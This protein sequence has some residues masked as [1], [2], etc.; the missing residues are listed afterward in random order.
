[1]PDQT[2]IQEYARKE[3]RVLR[4][5]LL[6]L[7]RRN[8]LLNFR[9]RKAAK[10]QL[11]IVD[12]VLE[13]TFE[14]LVSGKE[15]QIDPLPDPED[16]TLDPD[17][18][19]T[20]EFNLALE[21]LKE[22]DEFKAKAETLEMKLKTESDINAYERARDKLIREIK[23][24]VR[25]RLGMPP[26]G[27]SLVNSAVDWAKINGIN[28][29]YELLA[30]KDS[31]GKRHE[32]KKLQTLH[33]HKSLDGKLNALSTKA[34]LIM[35][36]KGVNTLY[37]AFSFL[38]WYESKNSNV[39]LLSPLILLPLAIEKDFKRGEQVY[40]IQ[41]SGDPV[42]NETLRV[43]LQLD[44]IELPQIDE[45]NDFNLEDYL[46]S[47]KDVIAAHKRWKIHRYLTLGLFSFHKIAMYED[48]N[49][50]NG[51]E[52]NKPHENALVSSLLAGRKRDETELS[53]HPP[54]YNPDDYES[55]DELPKLI[56]DSDSSQFSAVV[57][58]LG[59]KNLIIQGPPGTGKSQTI[60]NIIGAAMMRDKSV[61]FVSEKLSALQVVKKRLDEFGIGNYCLEIHS[62]KSNRADF[63]NELSTRLTL[64]PPSA[65]GLPELNISELK[66][67][68]KRL[69]RYLDMLSLEIGHSK[70]TIEEALWLSQKGD[71]NKLPLDVRRFRFKNAS[72]I[73]RGD[74]TLLK[75]QLTSL[76]RIRKDV[77]I[78]VSM[79]PWIII[80]REDASS[81][82]VADIKQ[83]L[84]MLQEN[85]SATINNVEAL[86]ESFSEVCPADLQ[87][88]KQ[89]LDTLSNLPS[90][91]NPPE[92]LYPFLALT[93][94]T[95]HE[96]ALKLQEL[97]K[98]LSDID[99]QVKAFDKIQGI[100]H[101][102][103][104]LRL[105]GDLLD[106]LNKF[107]CKTVEELQASIDLARR[108][109]V[110][111]EQATRIIS[112]CKEL[113]PQ[114]LLEMSFSAVRE[115]L[116]VI[117][118]IRNYPEAIPEV[119]YSDKL[120]SAE[121]VSHIKHLK[122]K[123]YRLKISQKSLIE[124]FGMRQD[125]VFNRDVLTDTI[126][127]LKNKGLF[128]FFRGKYRR[129]QKYLA[130]IYSTKKDDVAAIDELTQISKILD[131][132]KTIEDDSIFSDFAVVDD[133]EKALEELSAMASWFEQKI[134]IQEVNK[135]GYESLFNGNN[136]GKIDL[137]K[138]Q[139]N[140]SQL[141]LISNL[142]SAAEK[143]GTTSVS[144]Y[145]KQLGSKVT[146]FE[147]FLSTYP[148]PSDFSEQPIN[149]L[150]FLQGAAESYKRIHAE[151]EQST[152]ELDS[153]MSAA[154]GVTAVKLMFNLPRVRPIKESQ[155]IKLSGQMMTLEEYRSLYELVL[156]LRA[157][158]KKL[159]SSISD[160][161]EVLGT[162]KI[163]KRSDLYE[164]RDLVEKL[165]ER[166][167]DIEPICEW[168]E[169]T[170]QIK[171]TQTNQILG[172]V[173]S[174]SLRDLSD[175]IEMLYGLSLVD[176]AHSQ[177]NELVQF[178]GSSLSADRDMVKDIDRQIA[179]VARYEIKEHIHSFENEA[180]RGIGHG[181]RKKF[182]EMSLIN[183]QTSLTRP[184][185]PPKRIIKQA[186]TSLQKLFP[187]FMMSP[188]TVAEYLDREHC[189]FD[190]VVFDEA[191]QVRPEDALG[192]MLRANQFVV[193][194]D[195]MQLP[196]TSFFSTTDDAVDEELDS[197]DLEEINA[198]E[199]ILEKAESTFGPS[200]MLL[201]HYR[202]QHP[203]LIA[204]SNKEFYRERLNIFPSPQAHS[205]TMG[206][207]SHFVREGA[208]A[209]RCNLPEAEELI[210]GVTNHIRKY[211]NESIGIVAMNEAQ[212]D[213]ISGLLDLKFAQ[214]D[215]VNEY[216]IRWNETL[217]PVF[218]KNLENVQGDE[219]DVVFVSTVYGKNK[220]GAMFQR[221][222]PVN[223]P[224][225][226]RRLNVLFTRAKRSVQ[227]Y[228][229]LTPSDI[230]IDEK[231]SRGKR[232]FRE[233]LEY[234][235]SGRLEAG[236]DTGRDPDSEFEIQVGEA[237]RAKGYKCDYQVGVSGFFIDLAVQHPAHSDHYILGVECDG[238]KYH[239]FKSARDRDR[240][241]E[242]ALVSKGWK[243][244]RIWSTDWFKNREKEVERLISRIELILNR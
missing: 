108:G 237:L 233:Y 69:Q 76:S 147:N 165:D 129:A 227:L 234:A 195:N 93:D 111:L 148:E 229:S 152:D 131:Q 105:I 124:K 193:V 14:R 24:E 75:K 98:K 133:Y 239:S 221:F 26:L 109:L 181:P 215:E 189:E 13:F 36:E 187:C 11:R 31:K 119:Y 91:T 151:F 198:A 112:D 134:N 238:A 4:Q 54:V 38:E 55:I 78:D 160:F 241:R 211:P 137:L 58:A 169:L 19:K 220:D 142:L 125:S 173:E 106:L 27:K 205:S 164:M 60:S 185:M 170:N 206:V 42:I 212:R 57:D 123:H 40:T 217:E 244:H 186:R 33:F 35:G 28:P 158:Y 174:D 66:R 139:F 209:A 61:L 21:E 43:K 88:V 51:S 149:L 84:S 175:S 18:E 207:K 116:S 96:R 167:T 59:G 130:T 225:G 2:E 80:E 200:R 62:N 236:V 150:E 223:H 95:I 44:G 94:Q 235:R 219:R 20:P 201:W 222:G 145:A 71:Y 196:P 202:S 161:S 73:H 23:D 103:S 82:L 242:D 180:P 141:T 204:Y 157:N 97:R 213:L 176:A 104:N 127:E 203:S 155:F 25:R 171:R 144:D 48:L 79:S 110:E 132:L 154:P 12:E 232:V 224:N 216:R 214:D 178:S 85:V 52:G 45:D 9:H 168:V 77:G 15:F 122:K 128:S 5:K 192:A 107:G 99:S 114:G 47:V 218:I 184:S 74:I 231:S 183:H 53:E 118:H 90:H 46:E 7:S 143:A 179:K 190:L 153:Q 197:E 1:M 226:Y 243:I 29:N 101:V 32:D 228:T 146:D 191:S 92:E 199:S 67:R 136:R 6:D 10:N 121:T 115:F 50:E 230:I 72:T 182:T 135:L 22:E 163:S 156:T 70:V 8:K 64:D 126:A 120:Q 159:V 34:S 39:E 100:D 138:R 89:I 240:L 30:S 162:E 56:M 17:D 87:G 177:H 210:A 113:A 68:R 41:A 117:E 188:L 172:L 83:Y 49:P 65:R 81:R 86:K 63:V 16:D 166:I 102:L 140:E 37:A 3:L 194:G 208:Y